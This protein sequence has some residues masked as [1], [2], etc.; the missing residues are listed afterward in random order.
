MFGSYSQ[1]FELVVEGTRQSFMS[2]FSRLLDLA[3]GHVFDD[4]ESFEVVLKAKTP[5]HMLSVDHQEARL[6]AGACSKSGTYYDAGHPLIHYSCM[7]STE[8][9]DVR[10]LFDDERINV[11]NTIYHILISYVGEWNDEECTDDVEDDLLELVAAVTV[12]EPTPE[13]T[14][15]PV[16]ESVDSSKSEGKSYAKEDQLQVYNF[17]GV[18]VNLPRR[19]SSVFHATQLKINIDAQ[20]NGLHMKLLHPD[21]LKDEHLNGI[22]YYVRH[23]DGDRDKNLNITLDVVVKDKYHEHDATALIG[24]GWLRMNFHD[25]YVNNEDLIDGTP[26]DIISKSIA[27][28]VRQLFPEDKLVIR[29]A[30][31]SH[32]IMEISLND[33][34]DDDIGKLF[35]LEYFH[36]PGN[37]AYTQR[38]LNFHYATC[39]RY[40]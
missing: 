5:L 11:D 17:G 28:T 35:A 10:E 21:T 18:K 38:C 36:N 29:I 9:E 3:R 31:G 26:D 15:E 39:R 7:N 2:H 30:P 20:G 24:N 19:L 23:Q 6:L 32:I 22:M 27:G 37:G 14:P 25:V 13:P 4:M 34:T 12:V 40:I 33:I 1:G 16:S 8:D